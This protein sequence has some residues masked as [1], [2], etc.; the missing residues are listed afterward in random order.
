MSDS[1]F[2]FDSDLDLEERLRATVTRRSEGFEP[3]PDLPARIDAR[4]SHHHRRRQLVAGG[5]VSAAAVALAVVAVVAVGE[6]DEDPIRMID[7]DGSAVTRPEETTPNT[8]TSSPSTSPSTA[9]TSTGSTTVPPPETPSGQGLDPLTPLSRDGIGPITAGM[10]LREAQ[11]AAGVTITPSAGGTT[12][13]EALIDGFDPSPILVV[14]PSGGDP[15]D[16]IVR[17]VAG[18][19]LPSDEG[20]MV[21]QSRVELLAS[22]GQP[23]R[24]EDASADVGFAGDLLVFEAGGFAYGALVVD[25]MVYGLQSGDPDWVSGADGCPE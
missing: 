14:E 10:T 7:D 17:A 3:S 13:V 20:A 15:L 18:S 16:G 22:L 12:C 1:D 25:D 2:D 21:G 24:T 23:T 11:E 6:R 8:P 19:V 5:L 9:D 4:V